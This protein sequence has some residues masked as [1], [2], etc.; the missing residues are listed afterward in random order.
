V[1]PVSTAGV[2]KFS[3]LSVPRKQI[4]AGDQDN[5]IEVS[6]TSQEVAKFGKP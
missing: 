6:L 5:E 4:V 2:P 1:T 3:R